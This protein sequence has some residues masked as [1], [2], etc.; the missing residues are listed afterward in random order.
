MP[1]AQRSRFSRGDASVDI[2]LTALDPNGPALARTKS[3]NIHYRNV[4]GDDKEGLSTLIRGVVERVRETDRGGM[5]LDERKG[6]V[7]PESVRRRPE[8][9][10]TR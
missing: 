9:T 7:G 8:R 1:S 5:L 3:F 10:P 2:V 6:L 4:R